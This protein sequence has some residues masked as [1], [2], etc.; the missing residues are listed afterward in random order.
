[1]KKHNRSSNSRPSDNSPKRKKTKKSSSLRLASSLQLPDTPLTPGNQEKDGKNAEYS[2]I[3]SGSYGCVVTP[4]HF[5]EDSQIVVE[6]KNRKENDVG[7]IFKLNLQTFE[8]ELSLL[9]M[10]NMIDP[11]NKFTPKLKGALILNGSSITDAQ[12]RQCLMNSKSSR[13]KQEYGEI[14]QENGGARIDQMTHKIT[15]VEFLKMFLTFINGMQKMQKQGYVHQDI[16]PNNVL[17]NE[18][19]ISLIDFGLMNHNTNIYD[20]ENTR[21]K[22][23]EYRFYPPEYFIAWLFLNNKIKV[24]TVDDLDNIMKVLN[25]PRYDYFNNL[26]FKRDSTLYHHYKN[27]IKN[28]IHYLRE[29]NLTSFSDIFTPS[30]ALK[31]DVFSIGHVL[32]SL[33]SRESIVFDHLGQENFVFSLH[34][35]CMTINPFNRISIND[36]SKALRSQL[37][38]LNISSNS[39][40]SESSESSD[41]SSKSPMSDQ[42]SYIP[43][44][45]RTSGEPLP[46]LQ[47]IIGLNQKS[48]KI[49]V[50]SLPSLQYIQ[51]LNPIFKRASVESLPSLKEMKDIMLLFKKASNESLFKSKNKSSKLR[52]PESFV[53]SKPSLKQHKYFKS[54]D[55]DL[56]LFD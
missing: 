33:L 42:N 12:T 13:M 56:L 41:T 37:K 43:K 26:I 36:I 31:T 52:T 39:A 6:Y 48:K 50:E 17:I 22:Y 46:D 29:K 45:E 10:V 19:K 28:F 14:I 30:L 38:I 54:P 11:R 3:D 23:K 5:T 47:D 8:E 35:S 44:L 40:S 21:L 7:K 15:Y 24:E 25:S 53:A 4:P 9:Q 55:P 18:K 27:G 32:A 16:K 49:M 51:G 2:F 1:M 20:I 34:Y